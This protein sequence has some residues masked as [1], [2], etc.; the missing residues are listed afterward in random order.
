MKAIHRSLSLII[1]YFFVFAVA[2]A[3]NTKPFT[4]PEL[5]SWQGGE[6]RFAPSGRIVVLSQAAARVAEAFADDYL[7]MFGRNL[8]VVK[9]KPSAGD[10]VFDVDSSAKSSKVLGDEGYELA[11]GDYALLSAATPKGVFWGTRTLLQMS[12]QSRSRS[13]PR[14][15][16]TDVPAYPLRGLMLDCGRKF[17]PMAYLSQLVKVMAYYKMNALQIH[18]NDN[19]F[20]EYFG[21][22]WAKTP[23]AFRLESDFFPGLAAADGAYTK[24]EFIRF[25]EEAADMFVEIIPEIDVPAHCLAFSRYRPSLGSAEYGMDHLDLANPATIPFVDSLFAEYC[26]GRQPVFRGKYVHV[27]TD[28]YSNRDPHVVELFR[29]F[30]DHYIRKVESYGKQA[31]A[32]CSLKHAKGKTPVKADGNVV[33]QMWSADYGD[34]LE[35]KR[36][37]YSLVSIP[38]NYLYIVPAAGYYDD[39]LD[40]PLIYAAYTPAQMRA[41]RLDERDPQILG[42]MFAL[43]NDHCGNG[44]TVKDIHHRLFPAIPTFAVKTWTADAVSLP[45]EEYDGRRKFLSEAPGVNELARL[46]PWGVRSVASCPRPVLLPDQAVDWLVPEIGY[47]Y[48]VTFT[49]HAE[50]SER[51][52][53][54]FDGPSSRLYLSSPKNGRLAFERE[55]YLNEFDYIVPCG[56]DVTLT[57]SGTNRETLLYVDGKVRQVLRPLTVG[58]AQKDWGHYA[59]ADTMPKRRVMYYQRT[60]VFPLQRTGNFKGR[61]TRLSVANY[62]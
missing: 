27:G 12:E 19:G 8:H 21:D 13:L 40:E 23:A 29:A 50:S 55:G 49:L 46:F 1:L 59:V 3:E 20:K 31:M 58:N 60:L 16:A 51:G 14:G 62:N 57:I 38:D 33:M 6:G 5:S 44:I 43:W 2:M 45:W 9:G 32:W 37:G 36:A 15:T 10:F 52:D 11:I 18:L 39:Y 47:D 30:T 22:D 41:V 54:L 53:V 26:A 25:Q 48:S 24:A 28:E 7:Q 35:A 34:P 17:I 61:I 56:R 4:V 42:G